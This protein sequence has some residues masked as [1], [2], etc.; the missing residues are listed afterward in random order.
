MP[1]ALKWSRSLDAAL[2]FKGGNVNQ[3]PLVPQN[4]ARRTLV[5]AQG[6]KEIDTIT[7]RTKRA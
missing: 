3:R 7:T 4:P 6:D 2:H 5:P 1:A